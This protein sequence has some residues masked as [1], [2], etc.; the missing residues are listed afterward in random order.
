VK[1]VIIVFQ[2]TQLL[3]FLSHNPLEVFDMS[4]PLDQY[5]PFRESISRQ[6]SPND[7][8][9]AQTN[10]A[11]QSTKT[12]AISPEQQEQDDGALGQFFVKIRRAGRWILWGGIGIGGIYL[13]GLVYGVLHGKEKPEVS[14][15]KRGH[16][17][18]AASDYEEE[19]D[20]EYQGDRPVQKEQS[21][22]GILKSLFCGGGKRPTFCD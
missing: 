7:A 19:E 18:M 3:A 8:P 5:H 17:Q 12:P 21:S 15:E 1:K 4:G 2:Q 13:Y 22:G 10:G 11:S 14:P 9:G 16:V 20:W 6:A